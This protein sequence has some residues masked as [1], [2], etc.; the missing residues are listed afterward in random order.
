[1][2]TRSQALKWACGAATL[3]ILV[4]SLL[5]IWRVWDFD[6]FSEHWTFGT[7]W[8]VVRHFPT[9][10]RDAETTIELLNLHWWNAALAPLVILLALFFGRHVFHYCRRQS[11]EP[12]RLGWGLGRLATLKREGTLL[13]RGRLRPHGRPRRSSVIARDP[14]ATTMER[15]LSE[16]ERSLIRWLL[17]HGTAGA[18]NYLGQ[19]DQTRVASQCPCG[20]P[21]VDL[22]VGEAPPSVGD[23]EIL[24]DYQW[25]DRGDARFG[26]FVYA[27]AGLLAG[28]EVWSIDGREMPSHLPDTTELRPLESG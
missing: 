12:M 28:L 23:K 21:T 25:V 20:C 17:E 1:M 15:P 26:V 16:T 24:S 8:Q 13:S 7:L 6:I 3:V 11:D 4:A 18:A 19:L 22:A 9:N 5:P 2:R 14:G 27:R 10:Y